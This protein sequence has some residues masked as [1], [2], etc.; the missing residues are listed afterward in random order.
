M[1]SQRILVIA[2]AVALGALAWNT[3]GWA[4][5]GFLFSGLVLWFLLNYTR[6]ITV[7]KRAADRPIGYVGSAVMLNTKLR[8]KLPLLHVIALTRSL[9][10]RLTA[11]G[12]EPEIYVWRDN[13]DSTVTCE[14][15]GG[16]LM[17]W[18]LD[19][20]SQADV[21]PESAPEDLREA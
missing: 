16:R 2:G 7:M 6:M 15:E 5:L 3:G 10:K 13:G 17:R 21:E 4:G 8:P 1:N 14:F 9:G 12:E 20:P 11:E 19:R 18:R